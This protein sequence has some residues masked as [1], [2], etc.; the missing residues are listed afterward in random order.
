MWPVEE[1]SNADSV[2]MRAHRR[3]FRG[4]EL[5]VGV[6]RAHDG[7]MS[8]NWEKYASAEVTKQQARKNPNDNAVIC[9]VVGDIRAIKN[10]DVKHTPKPDNMAHSD[11]NLPDKREE[12][13]E[14][15]VLLLRVAAIV[16]P[17]S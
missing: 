2:F 5:E 3:H 10:L 14:V 8:A 4:G 7:G 11:V 12:L 6:F 9:L 17:L 13:T 15:R 16:I 1:I